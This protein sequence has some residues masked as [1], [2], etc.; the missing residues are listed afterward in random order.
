MRFVAVSALRERQV[1]TVLG[2]VW[3]L[4][5]PALSIAVYYVIFGLLLKT[6]RGVD[7]FVL[8][9]AVGVFMFGFTQRATQ[10]GASSITG[11]AGLVKAIRFPRAVLPITT[12]ITEALTS[13]SS[14]VVM[15]A[16]AALTGESPRW[17][18]LV[19]PFVFAVQFLFNTGAA[20]VAARMTVH[21]RDTTQL[22][23]FLFRMLFYGS[24]VVFN[25]TSYATGPHELWFVLNP[26]YCF[27][28][29]SRWCILGE[30]VRP[31]VLV[32]TSLWTVT[33]LAV[34]FVW[35]KAGEELYGRD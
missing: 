9:L 17:Q 19:L 13:F 1:D 18:W 2:N 33:L 35:F 34:G 15:F 6:D 22:L 30:D 5:N 14:I 8:Y 25:V 28:N 26:V 20:L 31:A 21:V 11:N 16:V 32:S 7:N 29:L 23:P 3:H 12:S 24:G 10:S 27:L 4:L